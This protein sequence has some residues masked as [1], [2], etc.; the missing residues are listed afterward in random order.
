LISLPDYVYS[1]DT[2]RIDCIDT[3]VIRAVSISCAV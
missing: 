1:F 3:K 2:P